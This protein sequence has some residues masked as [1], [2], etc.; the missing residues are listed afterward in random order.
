MTA[1]QQNMEWRAPG[2][3]NLSIAVNL[4]PRQF[5]D[6]LLLDDVRSIL[7]STGMDPRLLELE[8]H[9]GLLTHNVDNTLRILGKLKNMGVR[10]A[11]DDF[12]TGYSSLAAL[13]K[14]PL[15]TVK[16]DRSLI[17]DLASNSEDRGL[18]DAIITMG[19]SLA[20]TVVAQGVETKEQ[21]HFLREHACDELQGFYFNRPLPADLSTQCSRPVSGITYTGKRLVLKDE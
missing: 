13:R 3:P 8:I 1:C 14:F 17:R 21:A 20:V 11:V 4:T 6:E 2:F 10:I 7:A 9:E 12:G 5:N 15:D 18:A 19:K 16:I